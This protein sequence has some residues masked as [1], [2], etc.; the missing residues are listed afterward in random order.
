M[1]KILFCTSRGGMEEEE[2]MRIER[3]VLERNG[4]RALVIAAMVAYPVTNVDPK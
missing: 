4:G 1:L 3:C 2:V